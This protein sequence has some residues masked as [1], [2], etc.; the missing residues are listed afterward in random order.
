ME[1]RETNDITCAELVKAFKE[2]FKWGFDDKYLENL[3]SWT[4]ESSDWAELC[5]TLS[6]GKTP[7][8]WPGFVLASEQAKDYLE[9]LEADEYE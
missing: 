2:I 9:E 7:I 3:T 6:D 1:T 8:E 4:M 5:K